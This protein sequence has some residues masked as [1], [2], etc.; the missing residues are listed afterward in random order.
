MRVDVR[1]ARASSASRTSVSSRHHGARRDRR[2]G[3]GDGRALRSRRRHGQQRA[4]VPADGTDRRRSS[5]EDVDVFYTSGVK[6]TLWAMQAVYPHMARAGLGSHRELRVVDGHHRWSRLR[7]V[8][9]VEGGD[10]RAHPHRGA[11][12][13]DGRHRRQLHRAGRRRPPRRRRASRARATGIFIENCPMGRQGDPETDIGPARLVP[14]LR[15]VP[16]PHRPHVHG[17]RWSVHVGVRRRC[18]RLDDRRLP[19]RRAGRVAAGRLRRAGPSQQRRGRAP[20]QRPA[21][22]LHRSPPRRTVARVPPYRGDRGRPREVH[23][24]Y[25]SE[26]LPSDEYV[27]AMRY[28]A[29]RDAA[30][31]SSSGSSKRPR[32]GRSRGRG[33]SQVFVHDGAVADFPDFY[34]EVVAEAEGR[35]IEPRPSVRR[36]AVRIVSG[37]VQSSPRTCGSRRAAAS[38]WARRSTPDCSS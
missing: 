26:G 11:R 8:Q 19:L 21:R 13:G 23:V 10:P 12:V 9:R 31:S 24:P 25:E 18:S 34:W 38:S 28:G 29:A 3:R 22:R 4:D 6:G 27:G 32:A 30:Q 35:A 36:V 33:S 7:R 20:L 16:L 37:A 2:D 14:L 5:D 15:R 17:R 1:R